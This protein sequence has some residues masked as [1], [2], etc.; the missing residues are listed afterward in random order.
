MSGQ[1]QTSRLL[2]NEAPLQVLPSLA[3]AIGLNEAIVLQQIHF[4]LGSHESIQVDDHR[5][6]H[7]T[8]A[9][10]AAQ[11]AWWNTKTVQRT[12]ANLRNLKL[13]LTANHNQNAWDHTLSYRVDYEALEALAIGH[14]VTVDMDKKSKSDMDKTTQSEEDNLSK[15]SLLENRESKDSMEP[16]VPDASPTPDK[17]KRQA[18]PIFDWVAANIFKVNPESAEQDQDVSKWIGANAAKLINAE[19]L[20]LGIA[21]KTPLTDEQR[22]NLAAQLPGLLKYYQEQSPGLT[23]PKVKGK[24][25]VLVTQWYAAGKPYSVIPIQPKF[26][27]IPHDD[28]VADSEAV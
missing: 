20:K 6:V 11:F 10:W 19:K 13:V 18:N 8:M 26:V 25:G 21:K 4:L 5:W 24:F 2:I 16:A 28:Y 14:V 12:F 1:R 3:A 22:A 17:P 27:P 7:R 15:S 23:P 9:E